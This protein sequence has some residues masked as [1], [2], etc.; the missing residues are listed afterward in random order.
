MSPGQRKTEKGISC[1]IG[2]ILTQPINYTLK[3]KVERETGLQEL[4]A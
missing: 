2:E 3:N 1:D 4:L